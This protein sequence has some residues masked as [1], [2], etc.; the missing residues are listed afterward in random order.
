MEP[1]EWL[2][3]MVENNTSFA[4]QPPKGLDPTFYHT[5][6]YD[7]DMEIYEKMMLIKQAIEDKGD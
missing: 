6:S 4:E 1:L 7:G 3:L 2:F 5:L